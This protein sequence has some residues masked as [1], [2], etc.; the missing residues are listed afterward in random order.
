MPRGSSA[1]PFSEALKI[2]HKLALQVFIGVI[3]LF[4]AYA[5]LNLQYSASA[6]LALDPH[7]IDQQPADRT[8]SGDGSAQPRSPVDL[9]WSALPDKQITA[10]IQQFRLNAGIAR[11]RARDD[12]FTYVRSNISFHQIGSEASSPPEIMLSYTGASP[13]AVMEVTNALA[14]GLAQPPLQ[15]S[16]PPLTGAAATLAGELAKT[17]SNLQLLA[18]AQNTN[19]PE[20]A[21]QQHLKTDTELRAEQRESDIQ[22]AEIQEKANRAISSASSN[23]FRAQ[24]QPAQVVHQNPAAVALQQQIDIAQAHLTALRQRYTDEYPDVVE[25]RQTVAALQAKLNRLP[26]EKPEP[27]K[28]PIVAPAT[29]LNELGKAQQEEQI[30]AWHHRL[31]QAIAA[32]ELE[33]DAL[34]QR[35]ADVKNLAQ[36]YATEQQ[37]YNTLLKAQQA[38]GIAPAQGAAARFIVVKSATTAHAL[39]IAVKPLFWISA[40]LTAL[41]CGCYSV[42][43]AEQFGSPIDEVPSR[44]LNTN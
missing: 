35:V 30:R 39:G 19:A 38:M 40:L 43:L 17:R 27:R 2:R 21:L 7:S 9:A 23:A 16:Q 11:I 14:Q 12:L 41:F 24:P 6:V 1:H 20:E 34:R 13:L 8:F 18:K 29:P 44:S 33:T 37:R 36:D 5:L 15:T 31:D 3:L 26:V 4:G 42:Y 22:L 32:N 10:I 28:Q 25:A